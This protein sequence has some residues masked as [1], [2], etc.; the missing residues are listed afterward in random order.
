MYVW[1]SVRV[2]VSQSTRFYVDRAV[3]YESFQYCKANDVLFTMPA[4]EQNRDIVGGI[5]GISPRSSR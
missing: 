2:S 4:K 3:M 5:R 1:A